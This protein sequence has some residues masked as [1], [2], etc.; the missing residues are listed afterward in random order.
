MAPVETSLVLLASGLSDFE[1]KVLTARLGA[2]GIVWQVRG[3]VDSVYPLGDI[4][5]L[6]REDELAEAMTMLSPTGEATWGHDDGWSAQDQGG[7]ELASDSYRRRW[8]LRALL[9]GA[10]TTFFLMRLLAFG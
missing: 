6:V 1:A 8:W 4:A 7:R 3:I 9:I 2:E 10:L 5:V